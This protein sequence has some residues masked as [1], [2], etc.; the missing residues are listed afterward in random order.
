MP[1]PEPN[2]HVAANNARNLP[3]NDVALPDY[4]LRARLAKLS[5]DWQVQA[6]K[7]RSLSDQFD[8]QDDPVR[9]NNHTLIADTFQVCIRSLNRALAKR[10]NK[11]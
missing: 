4:A 8:E 2:P 9:S 7:H 5:C 6:R 11:K 10:G 3:R 1:E